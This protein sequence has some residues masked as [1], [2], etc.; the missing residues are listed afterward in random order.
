MK[1]VFSLTK[2]VIRVAMVAVRLKLA[3]R[4]LVVTEAKRAMASVVSCCCSRPLVVGVWGVYSTGLLRIKVPPLSV[5]F[6]KESFEV[7]KLLT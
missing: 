7:R 2:P 4:P 1:F 6:S 3:S 5:L